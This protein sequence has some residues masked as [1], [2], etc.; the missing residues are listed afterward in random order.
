VGRDL[1]A[2]AALG[3]L[4]GHEAQVRVGL[5]AAIDRNHQPLLAEEVVLLEVPDQ[6]ACIAS[7]LPSRARELVLIR[8]RTAA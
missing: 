1:V 3:E 5:A 7:G 2:T 4:P 8:L 6:D